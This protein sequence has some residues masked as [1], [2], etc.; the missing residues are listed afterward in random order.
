MHWIMSGGGPLLLL[1]EKELSKWGGS[2]DEIEEFPRGEI[3]GPND[4][5]T[6]YDRAGRVDGYVGKILVGDKEALVLGDQ[7]T[8][9]TWVPNRRGGTIVRLLAAESDDPSLSW[10]D[11]VP[12]K[13]FRAECEFLV[14]SHRLVL[15]DSALAGR[16]VADYPG[17]YLV[18]ELAPGTYSVTSVTY[19][20]DPLTW[21]VLH[22]FERT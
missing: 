12:R 10:L 6:D 7:P 11:E 4:F 16:E 2:I 18:I 9:T 1:N 20:P 19:E 15:F 21:T 13:Q 22:R 8:P 14:D 17:E 5:P 3:F